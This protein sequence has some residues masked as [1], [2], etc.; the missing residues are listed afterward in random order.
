MASHENP[1]TLILPGRNSIDQ[2]GLFLPRQKTEAVRKRSRHNKTVKSCLCSVIDSSG[3]RHW[4]SLRKK[5]DMLW[6]KT[7]ARAGNEGT[8]HASDRES[9]LAMPLRN[10]LPGLR[11]QYCQLI[12][13]PVGWAGR[14]RLQTKGGKGMSALVDSISVW[15]CVESAKIRMYFHVQWQKCGAAS[16]R[17]FS[18]TSAVQ[19]N[20]ER[21][22][23]NMQTVTK[24]V[25]NSG[26]DIEKHAA[27]TPGLITAHELASWGINIASIVW[28][29]VFAACR[30]LCASCDKTQSR[31]LFSNLEFVKNM[32]WSKTFGH[33]FQVLRERT[34]D[35]MYT[36]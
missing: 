35:E 2:V 22:Q 9:C 20:Q 24:D 18:G 17:K 7:S 34:C 19:D 12:I 27:A 3:K 36:I 33:R 15:H 6:K 26:A 10:I 31:A 14:Q 21:S 29:I 4:L 16:G 1:F 28:E 30:R 23:S 8:S 25:K 5:Y 13:A 11:I 32:F